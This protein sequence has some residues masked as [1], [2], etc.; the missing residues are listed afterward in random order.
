[1]NYTSLLDQFSTMEDSFDKG[2]TLLGGSA[3]MESTDD[4][5]GIHE[6]TELFP[7]AS[8]QWHETRTDNTTT[9]TT[10]P[11]FFSRKKSTPNI[12][13]NTR[14][15]HQG[16]LCRIEACPTSESPLS[17]R[18]AIEIALENG[19][20]HELIYEPQH[21]EFMSRLFAILDTESRGLV[22]RAALMEF[23]TLRCPVFWRRDEDLRKLQP[24]FTA[25][26]TSPTFDEVWAAVSQC[27][28]TPVEGFNTAELGVEGWMI[29]CRFI[30]LA[31]YLEAKRQ[32]SAR[33]LQQ[34]MRHRNAPRGSELVMVDVPPPASPAPLCPAQLA[35]YERKGKTALP[36]PELDLDHSLVAA[37]DAFR[38][39]RVPY[40]FAGTVKVSLFGSPGSASLSCSPLEFAVTYS[41]TASIEDGVVVRRSF[42][43]MKWLNATF[44][45]HKV[46][47][48]TLCGRILPPFPGSSGIVLA[49]QYQNDDSSLKSAIGSTGGAMAAAAAGVNKI[50]GAAK[51][52]LGKYA[53]TKKPSKPSNKKADSKKGTKVVSSLALPENYYNP[54]SPMWKARQLERYLNYL[55]EHPALSTSFPLN[56]VLK[57]SVLIRFMMHTCS[58]SCLSLSLFLVVSTGKSVWS[59]GSETVPRGPCQGREEVKVVSPASCRRKA[60]YSILVSPV[61]IF[62]AA[63][64]V[65]GANGGPSGHGAAGARHSG[66]YWPSFGQC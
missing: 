19:D 23:V 56:T 7:F 64:F 41:P 58:L 32:F 50:T 62:G 51:S 55:L 10:T 34:T 26:G 49:A 31:Q 66:D 45:S 11:Q 4:S 14:V 21:F 9:T 15:P 35:D 8:E 3:P 42:D 2:E 6:E 27:S 13:Q 12:Q 37:H 60:I 1:M 44:A 33:H 52:V 25:D 54:N 28:S 65:L 20:T 63:K 53:S 43:D 17:Y 59:R 48:G 5:G 57:V 38:H 24:S 39:R 46:L 40:G 18:Y 30:A 61:W 16:S 47:G 36:L 22:G 29:F